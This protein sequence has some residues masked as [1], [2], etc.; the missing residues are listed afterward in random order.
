MAQVWIWNNFG[1]Q[2]VRA[3]SIIGIGASVSGTE[4][5]VTV[6]TTSGSTLVW[7]KTGSQEVGPGFD[8]DAVMFEA[9]GMAAQIAQ[10]IA[11]HE[12]TNRPVQVLNFMEEDKVPAEQ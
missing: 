10:A 6:Q 2:M 1:T 5:R 7:V 8:Y 12:T 3:D 11:I 9:Q 4:A